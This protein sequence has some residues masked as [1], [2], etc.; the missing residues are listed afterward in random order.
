MS[1]K[2]FFFESSPIWGPPGNI[3]LNL[4]VTVIKRFEGGKLI[5]RSKV[6]KSLFI[7]NEGKGFLSKTVMFTFK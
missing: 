2:G 3:S 1:S 7:A 5:L 4:L 6:L